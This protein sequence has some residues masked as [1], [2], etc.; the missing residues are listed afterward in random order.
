MWMS[1]FLQLEHSSDLLLGWCRP[2]AAAAGLP[3][4]GEGH[5]ITHSEAHL[6]CK[7]FSIA[8]LCFYIYIYIQSYSFHLNI[9]THTVYKH[10]CRYQQEKR[11]WKKCFAW[12][13]ISKLSCHSARVKHDLITPATTV[14]EGKA[15]SRVIF[16]MLKTHIHLAPMD[17]PG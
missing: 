8:S 7:N 15:V 16:I 3:C 14:S 9:N 6:C 2:I 12:L 13:V 5:G 17:K 10:M 4:R 11:L 1:V